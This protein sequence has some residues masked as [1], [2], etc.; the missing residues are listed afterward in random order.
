MALEMDCEH[1]PTAVVPPH[2]LFVSGHRHPDYSTAAQ[3]AIER[4]EVRDGRFAGGEGL[5]DVL[6]EQ[7]SDDRTHR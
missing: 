4:E 6:S 7:T 1:D 5:E 2:T 3:V